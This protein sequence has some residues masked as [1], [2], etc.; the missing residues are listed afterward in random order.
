MRLQLLNCIGAAIK[1]SKY[2]INFNFNST[3]CSF[4]F[5]NALKCTIL[6]SFYQF[7]ELYLCMVGRWVILNENRYIVVLQ[8]RGGVSAFISHAHM[9]HDMY[10]LYL[11]LSCLVAVKHIAHMPVSPQCST[12]NR[13]YRLCAACANRILFQFSV[14]SSLIHTP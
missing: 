5:L 2:D 12:K 3:F 10:T 9:G 8:A 14:D 13:P 7:N 1:L 4:L 6:Y 11:V